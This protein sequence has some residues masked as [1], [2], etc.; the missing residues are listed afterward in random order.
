MEHAEPQAEHRFLERLVGDWVL[1]SDSFHPG[2][3][4][5]GDWTETVRSINGLWFIAEG[6]GTMPDGKPGETLMTLGYDPDLGHFVGTWMA[7]MMT[8]LWIYQGTLEPD[9]QT[10]T[11]TSEGPDMQDASRTVLYRDVIF[12][13]DDNRRSF[14]GSVRQPDGSFKIFM[15]SEFRRRLDIA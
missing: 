14:S 1:V 11:L 6:V 13:H 3:T 9:G 15:T 5:P 8:R 4:P 10:L 12:F 7:S 2:D